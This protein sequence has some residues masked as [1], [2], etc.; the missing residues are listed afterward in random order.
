MSVKYYRAVEI[1]FVYDGE[2]GGEIA[3]AWPYQYAVLMGGALVTYD[4]GFYPVPVGSVISTDGVIVA[5]S[6]DEFN[7]KY[8]Q[9]PPEGEGEGEG[10]DP[11]TDV[12]QEPA[13]T[14]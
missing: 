13:S 7:E 2:N 9:L 14:L 1:A 11:N 10:D 12:D 3:A 5:A 4:A 6:M 8:N